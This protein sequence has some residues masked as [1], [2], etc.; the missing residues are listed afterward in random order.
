[1]TEGAAVDPRPIILVV[2][3]SGT[4][5]Y[6]ASKVLE[7]ALEE[8]GRPF[9]ETFSAVVCSG[10]GAM[11]CAMHALPDR[12]KKFDAVNAFIPTARK[13]YGPDLFRFGTNLYGFL[14][15]RFNSNQ[16]DR[17]TKKLFGDSVISEMSVRTMFLAFDGS[18]M[19]PVKFDSDDV[20]HGVLRIRD[21][22]S[23][24]MTFPAIHAPKKFNVPKDI[25]DSFSG[26]SS[27]TLLDPSL[28]LNDL[29]SFARDEFD[30][31]D[32]LFVSIGCEG[33]AG[34][35]AHSRTSTWGTLKWSD[36][37]INLSKEGVDDIE[38]RALEGSDVVSLRPLLG[39]GEHHID[40]CTW[41]EFGKLNFAA[42]NYMSTE[43]FQQGIA[44]IK[45]ALDGQ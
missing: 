42:E 16:R 26:L 22:V 33:P 31:I 32:P 9:N 35:L 13:V 28:S 1:M 4:R 10:A 37:L 15:P 7:R 21:V 11:V 43:T 20:S 29:T 25:R 6:I 41:Q 12:F 24:S 23:G 3:G 19:R 36:N 27:M 34:T 18:A 8:I 45:V 2:S 17:E 40:D 44:D 30:Y 39:E 5:A 38:A 14:G